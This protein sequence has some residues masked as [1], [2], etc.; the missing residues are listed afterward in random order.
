M[1]ASTGRRFSLVAMAVMLASAALAGDA[2]AATVL[3]REPATL[4][5]GERVLIDDG[6]CPAGQVREVVAVG[7]KTVNPPRIERL[8][9]CVSRKR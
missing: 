5:L 2:A 9:Q 8:R 4:R 1:N 6:S 3:T 7:N